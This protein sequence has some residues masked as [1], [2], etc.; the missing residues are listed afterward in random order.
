[1][2]IYREIL[3]RHK[4]RKEEFGSCDKLETYLKQTDMKNAIT[5][6]V[7]HKKKQQRIHGTSIY[8]KYLH[9]LVNKSWQI[10]AFKCFLSTG[11]FIQY[12]TQSP[13]VTLVVIFFALALSSN[14]Q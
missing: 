6:K 11:H 1:M 10:G 5:K 2:Q 3:K 7:V 13:D 12:A 14:K 9:N 4:N 8:F